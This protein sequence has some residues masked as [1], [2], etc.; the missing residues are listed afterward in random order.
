MLCSCWKYKEC[1]LKKGVVYVYLHGKLERCPAVVESWSPLCCSLE[2]VSNALLLLEMKGILCRCWKLEHCSAAKGCC[3][4]LQLIDRRERC[5]ATDAGES[6]VL[7]F[8]NTL[9]F[10]G[11]EQWS[12]DIRNKRS[13]L[14]KQSSATFFF[15]HF[16]A[17]LCSYLETALQA[18]Y[19]LN[20][21]GGRSK[22]LQLI[23]RRVQWSAVF[24]DR[25]AMFCISCLQQGLKD[26]QTLLCRALCS[27]VQVMVEM[28]CRDH[29]L[30]RRGGGAEL[31]I[32]GSGSYGSYCS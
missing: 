32:R 5:A 13:A 27:V 24:W 9:I 18:L 30:G 23:G 3:N 29:T 25:A 14:S 6:I 15:Y 28:F 10:F 8:R 4:A 2:Y 20:L 1:S 21:L 12:A 11:R 17:M 26:L 16:E 22:T 19:I 31:L 7:C